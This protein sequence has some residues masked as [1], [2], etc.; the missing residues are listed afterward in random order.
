[1]TEETAHRTLVAVCE[2]V[3]LD[4][5]GAELIRIGSNAVYRLAKP[6]IVRIS[7]DS[8]TVENARRQV[9]VARWLASKSYP[10]TRA[11]DVDQ[12]I[13]L[14]G[15]VTT[16]WES[17]SER[18][19]YAPLTQVAELIRRLHDLDAPASLALPQ[20]QPFAKL[21]EYLPD[22]ELVDLSDAV[23]MRERIGQLRSRYDALDFA[24]KP[25]VIHGDANVGNVILDRDGDPLLIDLDS[26]CL[27]PR[28]WDLV[29]TALFFERFG[30][31][32]EDE[33]RA[34]V[35]VYGFDIMTWPGYPVLAEYREI[36][37]TLWLSQKGVSDERAAA[38]VHKR[39]EAIRTGGSRRDWAPF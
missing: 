29:Q 21:D 10:A 7:R 32:T 33:Y 20:S 2:Q 27:G 3:G 31:H 30:W 13:E 28:E 9:A 26:F 8:E 35:E 24:L 39:I 14:G 17:A 6:V 4:P 19:E 36:S 18:E 23:F 34:F 1:M 5:A 12:P 15:H 38:E 25:G 16:L 37:M 11:L 22:L